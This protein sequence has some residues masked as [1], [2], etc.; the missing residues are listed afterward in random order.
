MWLRNTQ[1][2]AIVGEIAS[3]IARRQAERVESRPYVF[4]IRQ[5]NRIKHYNR[6]W[7]TAREKAGLPGELMHDN[8]R[9]A[10]RNMDG[11]GVPHQVFS[12]L[13]DRDFVIS[14]HYVLFLTHHHHCLAH[15]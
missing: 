9:T 2:I 5:G 6:A 8:R 12:T 15:P 14:S 4:H 3:I 10:A 7:R 13:E 1:V 11:A